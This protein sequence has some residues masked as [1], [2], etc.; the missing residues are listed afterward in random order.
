MGVLEHEPSFAPGSS[1]KVRYQDG[2]K[3]FKKELPELELGDCLIHNCLIVHGS[4]ANKSSLPR[5]GL[6]LRYKSK[7]NFV[8]KDLQKNYDRELKMQ[9][10]NRK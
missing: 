1:Q 5:T 8:R 2:L 4:N 7:V 10:V 9:L 6:T 3:Y